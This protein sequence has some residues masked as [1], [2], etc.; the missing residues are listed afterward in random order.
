MDF[1]EGLIQEEKAL[2]T[3]L[4]L[5]RATLLAYGVSSEN[6]T[7]KSIFPS[8]ATVEKQLIWLFENQL[9][10]GLKLKEVQEVYNELLGSDSNKVDN[11]ARRLKREGKL[12]I[13]KYNGKNLHSYWGLPTWIEKNDFKNSHKPDMDLLPDIIKSEVIKE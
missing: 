3:R 7:G 10:Q 9:S 6:V 1:L 5:I 13:V 2:Q 8:K 12:V 11:T 4:E